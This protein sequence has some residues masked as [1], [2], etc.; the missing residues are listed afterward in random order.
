[1]KMMRWLGIGLVIAALFGGV[2][3]SADAP[4][5]G[6]AGRAEVRFLEGMIDHHMM[7][8]MMASD[9]LA[10]ASSDGLKSLCQAIIEAQSAEIELMRGWLKE[11]Y[12]IEYANMPMMDNMDNMGGMM[13]GMMGGEPMMMMGMM[14]GLSE[15]TG[16][17]YDIAWMEAMIDHHDDALHMSER[18]LRR[19]EHA[20]LRDLAQNIIRAQSAEIE[21][22]EGMIRDLS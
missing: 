11:W 20:D 4:V 18:L 8:L 14:A 22:M 10:K 3:V 21:L 7:A 1:M 6:R 2:M 19:V 15:L 9:C 17:E 5:E 13:G 12:S 16:T